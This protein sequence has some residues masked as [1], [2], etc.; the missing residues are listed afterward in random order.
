MAH[1]FLPKQTAAIGARPT[2]QLRSFEPDESAIENAQQII[3]S[4]K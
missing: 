3:A 1:F 2:P 4:S